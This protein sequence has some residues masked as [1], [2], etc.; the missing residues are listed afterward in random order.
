MAE[1]MTSKLEHIHKETIQNE[2][3]SEKKKK[4]K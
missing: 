2:S 1:K 4:K 3:Q